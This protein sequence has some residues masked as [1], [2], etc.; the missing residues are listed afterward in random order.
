MRVSKRLRRD[1]T[2]TDA[3]R[4]LATAR[5]TY[6]EL[7][8][9]ASAEEAREMAVN[10]A[11]LLGEAVDSRLAGYTVNGLAIGG[12]RAPVVLDGPDP[13]SPCAR[14]NCLRGGDVF[15]LPPNDD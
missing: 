14:G 13:L 9:D 3:D 15:A 7:N 4:L 1:F 5:R 12:W 2:V 11:G 8:P 10:Y 6:R